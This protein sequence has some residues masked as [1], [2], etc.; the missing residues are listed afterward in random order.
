MK[1]NIKQ[2]LKKPQIKIILLLALLSAAIA[3]ALSVF[4]SNKEMKTAGNV[5]VDIMQCEA[6]PQM[7]EALLS[8]IDE[9][10]WALLVT[11]EGR[12][13]KDLRFLDENSNPITIEA[14]AGK[15]ILVN[16]WATWCGPCKEEMPALDSLAQSFATD[17]FKVVTINL[18]SGKNGRGKAQKFLDEI[19][20]KNLTL[21]A[22]PSFKAFEYLRDN[23]VALGLPATLLLDKNGCELA[24]LQG[25]AEWSSKEAITIIEKL[26]EINKS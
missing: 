15:P 23:G 5:P 24:V 10:F 4:V 2:A 9:E 1:N 3:I 8:V 21:Y 6:Q 25:P 20:A 16:F 14:F 26:I 12:G 19:A 11:A 22:D 18:D 17:K 7:A 13:Y